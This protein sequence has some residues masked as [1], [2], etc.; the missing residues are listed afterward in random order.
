[1]THLS[2]VETPHDT[3]DAR[4]V[5]QRSVVN[6]DL[7]TIFRATCDVYLGR[8]DSVIPVLQPRLGSLSRA[9]MRTHAITSAKLVNAYARVGAPELAAPLLLET[10]GKADSLGSLS[11]KRE[12]VRA[13]PA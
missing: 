5:G 4:G 12:L 9:S 7:F 6:D 10:I 1:M 13:I 3:D 2:A 8:G 11:A